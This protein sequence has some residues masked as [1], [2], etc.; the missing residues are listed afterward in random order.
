MKR[1]ILLG[2]FHYNYMI[3]GQKIRKVNLGKQQVDT[4]YQCNVEKQLETM[5]LLRSQHYATKSITQ[6]RFSQAIFTA[7][8]GATKCGLHSLVNLI[9][10]NANQKRDET[11]K[12]TGTVWLCGR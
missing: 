4:V 9:S 11:R 3:T 8:P 6:V 10:K 7:L 2:I 12:V 5:E 1:N